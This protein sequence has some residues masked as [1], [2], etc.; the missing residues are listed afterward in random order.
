MCYIFNC[1]LALSCPFY[2]LS[3]REV[4]NYFCLNYLILLFWMDPPMKASPIKSLGENKPFI[5][6]CHC[7]HALKI[8]YNGFSWLSEG[9]S[10][11][12]VL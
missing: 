7:V 10:R 11:N 9:P 12:H 8:I 6:S 3:C 4:Q 2:I 5:Y 1:Q